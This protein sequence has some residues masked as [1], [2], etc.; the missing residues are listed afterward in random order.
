M[1]NT[2]FERTQL[3]AKNVIDTP[4]IP[5]IPSA[6]SP[7]FNVT[8]PKRPVLKQLSKEEKISLATG[9]ALAIGLGV[10]VI[11]SLP[12]EALAN[13]PAP[14]VTDLN[15]PSLD[16]GIIP[17]H[18]AAPKVS[19]PK[20][21][22]DPAPSF[23]KPEHIVHA[24]SAA[25]NT[26]DH[27][28]LEIPEHPEVAVGI[29][30]KVSFVEAF[31]SARE[32]VG[33]AGLF[34]WRGT[35]YTTFTAKEWE[36]VQDNEKEKWLTAVQ[37][38][39]DPDEDPSVSPVPPVDFHHVV[40]AERGAITWTGIDKNGDGQA[41][42]LMARI[43]GQPP[44]VL[45]DTDG[46]GNIDTRY[47]YQASSGRTFSSDIQP[48]AMAT[49]DV[50]KMEHIELGPDMGFYNNSG[51]EQISGALP[52]SISE[53]NNEYV[54]KLDSNMDNTV[55]AITYLTDSNGPVVGLD[56]DNDGQIELGFV[57][58][59]ESQIVTSVAMEPMDEM[60][61]EEPAATDLT[62]LENPADLHLY[63]PSTDTELAVN[64]DET[65]DDLDLYFDNESDLAD[66]YV[67]S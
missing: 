47:D 52:V 46:D 44:M 19:L 43:Q 16:L 59:S 62:Y 31:E 65:A 8:P 2:D 39:I 25:G 14:A 66:D 32:E 53:I 37:P 20:V 3:W 6:P 57:Y 34:A 54:V 55:D 45:M 63:Q 64:E 23:K 36:S 24:P 41:E 11:S 18:V 50:E 7:A 22:A 48:F 9:G 49:S 28:F 56:Y 15:A 10:I 21:T 35:Y 13:I 26:R 12:D 27:S 5:P 38:I 33:P 29:D 30:D 61:F 17:E 1:N 51:N 58:N 42:I 4:P 67:S 40:V 60:N